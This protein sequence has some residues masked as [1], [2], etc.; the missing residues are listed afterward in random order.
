MVGVAEVSAQESRKFTSEEG[1]AFAEENP[2]APLGDG[3]T[4]NE[5]GPEN[6]YCT[7]PR[8]HSGVHANYKRAAGDP[9]GTR[10]QATQYWVRSD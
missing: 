3:L 9:Y 2:R 6:I 1:L 5:P 10:R 4:C 7:R 8:G